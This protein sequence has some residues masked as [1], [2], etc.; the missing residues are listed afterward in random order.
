MVKLSIDSSVRASTVSDADS[1]VY[2]AC[3][4]QGL[5]PLLEYIANG[6]PVSRDSHKVI[7]DSSSGRAAD[8]SSSD[9]LLF[10]E[11]SVRLGADKLLSN[12]ASRLEQQSGFATRVTGAMVH[13]GNA[14]LRANI[15]VGLFLLVGRSRRLSSW[16]LI[17]HIFLLLVALV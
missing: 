7:R 2:I 17:L 10:P 16:Y 14:K 4:E 12:V 1:G 5:V 6:I 8:T 13:A 15:F 11:L 9:T 3:L